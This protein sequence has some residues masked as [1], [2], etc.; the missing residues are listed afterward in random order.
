MLLRG[1]AVH[2]ED[3]SVKS[4]RANCYELVA[5]KMDRQLLGGYVERDIVSPESDD[6]SSSGVSHL[7][8]FLFL[9]VA[10]QQLGNANKTNKQN[11]AA[12]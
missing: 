12:Q 1:A 8:V 9:T 2:L 10:H 11:I 4:A 6:R 5:N 7:S 3:I